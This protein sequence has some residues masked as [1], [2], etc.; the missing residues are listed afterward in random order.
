[1]TTNAPRSLPSPEKLER[2]KKVPA[3]PPPPPVRPRGE[4]IVEGE[5]CAKPKKTCQW[6]YDS[7]T[8]S[9]DTEC[10]DKWC[11]S[12]GTATDNGVKFCPMCGK[13]RVGSK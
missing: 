2:M 7:T 12:E 1:M 8:D 5:V 11:F 6:I 10:G 3:P 9:Y 4:I 13:Q